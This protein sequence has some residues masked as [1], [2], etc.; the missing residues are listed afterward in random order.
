[1]KPMEML[2]PP[3]YHRWP[4]MTFFAHRYFRWSVW[5]GEAFFPYLGIVG[6]AGLLWLVG[7]TTYRALKGRSLPGQSL[8]LGWLM[9]YATVGGLTNVL[10]LM[11]GFQIFR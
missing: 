8:S 5:H 6:I 10:A 9:G 11:A 1:L 3:V 4:A 2:L 7:A